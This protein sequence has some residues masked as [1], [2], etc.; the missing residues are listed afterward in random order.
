MSKEKTNK[1]GNLY[2]TAWD[3]ILCFLVS[4]S[5]YHNHPFR[6]KVSFSFVGQYTENEIFGYHS[7]NI[8]MRKMNV[9]R[10]DF[11]PFKW[12]LFLLLFNV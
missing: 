12:F 5:L 3:I 4:F 6:T 2:Q 7:Q 10:I 11:H 9:F 1:Q 8:R